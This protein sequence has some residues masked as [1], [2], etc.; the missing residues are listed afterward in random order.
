MAGLV[1]KLVNLVGRYVSAP[2]RRVERLS[3]SS[4]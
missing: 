4:L 3:S 2:T 1:E